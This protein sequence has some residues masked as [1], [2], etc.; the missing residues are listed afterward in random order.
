MADRNGPP[1]RGASA[2]QPTQI[3]DPIRN[4]Q[5]VGGDDFQKSNQPWLGLTTAF[6]FRCGISSN[7]NCRTIGLH[8]STIFSG[9]GRRTIHT[10]TLISSAM[11]DYGNGAARCGNTRWRRITEERAGA[12]SVFHFDVQ[13]QVA[14]ST[15][16]GCRGC[17]ISALNVPTVHFWPFDGWDVPAGRSVVAEVY[18]SLWRR[19]FSQEN[20]ND[21]QHDAFSVAEW[22]RRSDL[23]GTLAGFFAPTLSPAEQTSCH[24]EGWILGIK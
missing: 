10:C 16:P 14:K 12:K 2:T 9:T 24:I 15:H 18:P 21:D 22:M 1:T 3:L 8:F 5:M 11:A 6:R 17:A 20:R 7:T 4:R 23:D 19:G 13:G